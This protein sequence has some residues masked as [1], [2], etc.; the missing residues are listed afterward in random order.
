[1]SEALSVAVPLAWRPLCR[2]GGLAAWSLLG[3]S[4]A[5]L[6]QVVTLG[7][8]PASAAEAFRLLEQDPLVG[9]L[10]LDVLTVLALPLYYV[11]FLGLFAAL[12]DSDPARTTLAT[13]LAFPGLTLVL[14]T[15]M[16]LSMLPLSARYSTAG[17]EA[18]RQQMLAAG[19]AVLA[20]DMWHGTGAF[21]GAILLQAAAL[22]VS[23]VMLRTTVFS[24]LTAYAGVA[25]HGLDLLHVLVGPL[26]PGVA[27]IL[28]ALAGPLYLLWFPLVARRLV[29]LGRAEP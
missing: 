22:L 17:S 3:Y 8:Q 20:T 19:E 24:R 16:G 2:A 14:A 27:L 21:V 29:Q 1:V 9:L 11:V 4:V 18:V 12:K 15:P 28:M 10:R 25:T 26:L 23:L 5:T 6:V 13:A 7:G